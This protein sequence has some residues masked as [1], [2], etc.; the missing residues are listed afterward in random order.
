LHNLSAL[1]LSS[2]KINSFEILVLPHASTEKE[3]KK[4]LDDVLNS[5]FTSYSKS[6]SDDKESLEQKWNTVVRPKFR[7]LPDTDRSIAK[8]YGIGHLPSFTS[9]FGKAGFAELFRLRSQG[10]VN[11][12]TA[13]GSDRWAAHGV[14]L[15]DLNASFLVLI[16]YQAPAG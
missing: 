14:S 1:L 9:V 7:L 11:R 13:S 5:A 3:A 15:F 2:T 6:F 10:I 12:T 8:A 4:W 16:S